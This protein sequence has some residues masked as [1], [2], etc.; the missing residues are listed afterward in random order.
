MHS[1]GGEAE[2]VCCG[3]IWGNSHRLIQPNQLNQLNQPKQPSQPNQPNQPNPVRPVNGTASAASLPPYNS[4]A[5]S[6]SLMR[7]EG[8]VAP[9]P[10][11]KPKA[12]LMGEAKHTLGCTCLF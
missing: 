12:A 4:S 9:P 8:R 6:A 1:G 7:G 5:S 3:E 11:L 10:H 2:S